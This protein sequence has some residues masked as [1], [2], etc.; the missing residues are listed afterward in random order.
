M[1]PR[2]IE[3]VGRGARRVTRGAPELRSFEPMTEL[4]AEFYALTHRG[5]PGDVAFYKQACAG[6]ASVLEL[7]VG[8]G[9]LLPAL[10]EVAEIVVG[11]DREP[12]LLRAARRRLRDSPHDRRDDSRVG[13]VRLIRGDMQHF[14]LGRQFERILLPFNGLYCL[15]G[16]R[17][18][19]RCL[20]RIR[21]QLSPEGEFLFDVWAADEFQR[22]ARSSAHHDDDGAIVTLQH[23]G[24]LWD[25]FERSRLR[26]ALSRLDVTYTYVS[27]ERGTRLQMQIGHRYVPLGE[28]TR[29]LAEAG[30]AIRSRWG[31]FARARFTRGSAHLIVR[32]G[33]DL[34]E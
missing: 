9:R 3:G 25:V 20:R 28:L 11:L 6:A 5:N 21:D 34:T 8:Y 23:R 14:E 7:G 12:L 27:R 17:A 33:H 22:R 29:L 10:S 26:A 18:L 19:S 15:P 32:A 31:S 30:L 4:A 24:Q 1:S 13:A 2:T 16:R